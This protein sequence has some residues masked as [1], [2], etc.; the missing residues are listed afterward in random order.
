[1]DHQGDMAQVSWKS[2]SP[3]KLGPDGRK[4][5]VVGLDS[6]GSVICEWSEDGGA[7]RS[8]Y[9]TPSLLTNWIDEQRTSRTPA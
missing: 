6:V 9:V 5:T 1:V 2:G 3:V 8:G 4:M 7:K